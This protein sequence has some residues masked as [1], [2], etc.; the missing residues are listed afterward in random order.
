MITLSKFK[1]LLGKEADNLTD[2][3]IKEIRSTSYQLAEIAF[4]KWMKDKNIKN[5]NN[6]I[7]ISKT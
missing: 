1:K 3:Q 7:K 5:I 6:E 2:E 4:E